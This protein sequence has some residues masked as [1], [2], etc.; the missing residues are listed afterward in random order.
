M[1]MIRPTHAENLWLLNTNADDDEATA[2]ALAFYREHRQALDQGGR[3]I[4]CCSPSMRNNLGWAARSRSPAK[5]WDL[6]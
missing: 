2:N 3:S 1:R 5:G 6:S 4:R